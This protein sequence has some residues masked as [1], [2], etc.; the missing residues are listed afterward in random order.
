MSDRLYSKSCPNCGGVCPLDVDT[1]RYCKSSF[2]DGK[3]SSF[4]WRMP[5]VGPLRKVAIWVALLMIVVLIVRNV[6]WH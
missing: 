1:C 4:N 6:I 3:T 5:R 2:D